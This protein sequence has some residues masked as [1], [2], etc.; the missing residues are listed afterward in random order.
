M[1][2]VFTED[3]LGPE[4]IVPRH[5]SGRC[6]WADSTLTLAAP[7]CGPIPDGSQVEMPQSSLPRRRSQ[8]RQRIFSATTRLT[9]DE[10]FAPAL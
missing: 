5:A 10:R 6:T 2:F 1:R 3:L 4:T 8:L 9:P 7:N